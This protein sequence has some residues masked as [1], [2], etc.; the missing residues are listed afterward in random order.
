MC[1]FNYV[2]G[3]A[4]NPEVVAEFDSRQGDEKLPLQSF[5][6]DLS[7]SSADVAIALKSLGRAPL[8][9]G[10]VGRESSDEDFLL[11]SVL[12]R[13][14]I[15][16]HGIPILDR[17]SI[18]VLPIDRGGKSRVAGRRGNI[19]DELVSGVGETIRSYVGGSNNFRIAT[20]VRINEVPL[21]LE[22]F[23][24]AG[25]GCCVLNPNIALCEE[26]KIFRTLLRET[27]VLV[28]NEHEFKKTG[29]HS[30]D[31]IHGFGPKTV[32]VTEAKRGGVCSHHGK[33]IRYDAVNIPDKDTYLPG[34]G[35]WFLG[36][37]LSVFKSN[38]TEAS[39]S[40][41]SS[42]L[43]FAAKVSGIK[44]TMRGAANGPTLADL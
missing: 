34:A 14:A 4:V 33:F 21:A 37:F 35:D 38:I 3:F 10:L 44:V 1:D 40:T 43:N 16:F 12:R 15:P 18:A 26:V 2:V 11:S 36:G 29:F 23:K 28:I 5:H 7:G 13:S 17:T 24:G 41:I 6:I 39:P 42:A 20:G 9:L 32:I 31:E 25:E 27:D 8:L 30:I 19:I 22:L